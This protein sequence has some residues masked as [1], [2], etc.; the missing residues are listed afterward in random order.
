MRHSFAALYST[1]RCHF[2]PLCS[3]LQERRRMRWLLAMFALCYTLAFATKK[4]LHDP[5]SSRHRPPCS[6]AAALRCA[7]AP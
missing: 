5:A 7:A 2:A 6:D 1:L 4:F 3:V